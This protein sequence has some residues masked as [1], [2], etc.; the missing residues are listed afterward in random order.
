MLNEDYSWA[1]HV[2]VVTSDVEAT[3]VLQAKDLLDEPTEILKMLENISELS[4]S[5]IYRVK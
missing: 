4:D 3:A 2:K 5:E 1:D